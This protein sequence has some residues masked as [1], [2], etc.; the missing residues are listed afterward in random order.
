[1]DNKEFLARISS[2]VY[3]HTKKDSKNVLEIIRSYLEENPDDL[4]NYTENTNKTLKRCTG[5]YRD[6]KENLVR[7]RG[8]K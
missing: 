4:I 5:A 6:R 8:A 1:M 3:H 2:Y 7:W